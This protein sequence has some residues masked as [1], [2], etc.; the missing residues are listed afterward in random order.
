M[1]LDFRKTSGRIANGSKLVVP[2]QITTGQKVF[3]PTF[4]YKQSAPR[5]SVLLEQVLP[6]LTPNP[7]PTSTP[8][9][10]PT[11][12]VTPT[13]TPTVTPTITLT[14]S[15]TVTL[16]PTPS[17]TQTLT[18][19]IT[20]TNTPTVT[21]TSTPTN[22]P[23]QTPTVTPTQTPTVTPTNT[24]TPT[25]SPNYDAYLPVELALQSPLINTNCSVWYSYMVGPF[26]PTQPYPPGLTWIKL[27]TSQIPSKCNSYT[28][29]GQIGLLNGQSIYIQ[30][31]S[32]IGTL[33]FQSSSN[34]SDPCVSP[35]A[36]PYF[37]TSYSYGG[38][39]I[40]NTL[41]MRVNSPIITAPAP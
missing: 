23:T 12:S 29:F 33:V 7:T 28:L 30:V 27:G 13:I 24:M 37:T 10:S 3:Q 16:T 20:T 21:I 38:G 25:P 5:D 40:A 31:R 17:V 14:P 36:T 34:F 35:P 8:S 1:G 4:Q 6:F 15:P 18:P 22:T 39:P 19:T 26:N 2:G 41:R 32:G 11:P 9:P